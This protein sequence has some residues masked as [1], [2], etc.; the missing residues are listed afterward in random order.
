MYLLLIFRKYFYSILNYSFLII[1]Y[2]SLK[3]DFKILF[4]FI[5]NS[6]ISKDRMN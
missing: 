3:S 2:L 1:T 4:E 6:S 5:T